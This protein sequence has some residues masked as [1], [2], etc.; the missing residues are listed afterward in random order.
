MAERPE[1]IDAA[2][3]TAIERTRDAEGRFVE[4]P[5]GTSDSVEAAEVV[6][7]RAEEVEELATEARS[8]SEELAP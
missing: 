3:D 2:L 8:A 6:E 1:E 5:L 4:T 7:Q